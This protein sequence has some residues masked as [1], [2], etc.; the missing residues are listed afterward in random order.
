MNK[1]IKKL[2]YWSIVLLGINSI[3]GTGIFLT[4]GSVIRQAGTLAPLSYLIAAFFAI[5]LATVFASAAK[6]VK[7]NGAAYAYTTAAIGPN[8]GLYVGI[9][10]AVVG[11]IAWGTFATAVVKTLFEIFG[12]NFVLN[13]TEQGKNMSAMNI[14]YL[15]G[16]IV[17]MTVLLTINFL[18]N[19]IVELANNV[20]TIGK[21][22]A[23]AI[24][25]LVGI[26]MILFMNVNQFH[27]AAVPFDAT[28]KT[29]VYAYPSLVLFGTFEVI[30]KSQL[31]GV[32]VATISAL[33]AF[34]GFESIASA[35][36]EMKDPDRT[37]PKAIPVAIMI[38]AV[39]Y[40]LVIIVGMFLGP[41]Q[42]ANS[43]D[44]VKLAAVFTNQILKLIIVIGAT[45]SM[46]GINIA[47]SFSSPRIYLALADQH[48]LPTWV[49]KKT[50]SG[51]PVIAFVL[52]AV[53]AILFP[54]ALQ[55]NVTSLAGLSVISRFIQY[56]IVPIAV[57]IMAKSKKKQWEHIHRH[58][59]TDFV[60]PI[61]AV[62]ASLILISVYNYP[63]ILFNVKEGQYQLSNGWNVLSI[64]FLLL[65]FVVLP[66]LTGLYYNVVG[67]KQKTT[68]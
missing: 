12:T 2:G 44:T 27:M 17:L 8:T 20:T 59:V 41:E 47:A 35:S 45:I 53:P 65:M 7:T 48:V 58:Q 21:L 46:F 61:I 60:L 3:I 68:S 6:Y 51:V 13:V 15:L 29:G 22:S 9:T 50:M 40:L 54:V 33:Y 57:I 18:G 10:R 39:T 56:L 37:L 67:K 16:L 23:L 4:P 30:G 14:Y 55:F 32:I 26:V 34:T 49:S 66:I 52:T 11:S 38:V 62:I 43:S 42:I 24:F 28:T 36:E 64:T 19:R 25:V 5:V 63:S 1:R 31:S